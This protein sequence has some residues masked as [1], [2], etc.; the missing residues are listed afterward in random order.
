MDKARWLRGIGGPLVSLMAGLTSGCGAETEG[1]DAPARQLAAALSVSSE[2]LLPGAAHPQLSAVNPH[3]ASNR[4]GA[5]LI[6]TGR[7][8][9]AGATVKIADVLATSS[10]LSSTTIAVTTP[11]NPGRCGRV[12]VRVELTSGKSV[13]RPDLFSYHGEFGYLAPLQYAAVPYANEVA[14][15]DFNVDG[16]LDLVVSTFGDGGQVS[17]LSG[18]GDGTFRPAQNISAGGLPVS[19]VTAD[20]NRDGNPD[21]A[22]S[23]FNAPGTGHLLLGNG[24]GVPGTPFRAAIDFSTRED[25]DRIK[26]ADLNSDG[27]PDLLVVGDGSI[28][29]LLGKGDGTF[30]AHLDV[31]RAV[32][33]WDVTSGD[34]NGDGHP[35]LAIA[36][37]TANTVSVLLGKGDGTFLPA[38]DYAADKGPIFVAM[39]DVNADGKLDVVSGN[40]RTI[41]V[42]VG[43][44]DGKLAAAQTY[45]ATA[46]S[47][48]DLAVR[49]LDGDGKLD[50]AVVDELGNAVNILHGNGDGSFAAPQAFVTG[51]VPNYLGIG[52]FD[53][54]H[55]LD[56]VTTS[57]TDPGSVAVLLRECM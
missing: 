57:V 37:L 28:G 9:T 22:V 31:S 44:G 33:P 49:D 21:L 8:F 7:N 50:V 54:D 17:L 46:H 43:K 12:P 41:S 13:V 11:A 25:I 16:H 23:D 15:A 19:L 24:H 51:A 14:V 5:P 6:I 36:N 39:A 27:K 2:A 52:D 30:A 53:S 4:G 45:T 20:F 18:R 42:F 38:V 3:S 47:L 34:L 55:R 10:V 35:D 32:R 40:A 48:N 56:L 1:L 26:S 29:V